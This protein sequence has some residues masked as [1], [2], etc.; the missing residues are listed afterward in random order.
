MNWLRK[1]VLSK[2]VSSMQ[3][4]PNVELAKECRKIEV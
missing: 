3:I 2:Y 4:T 1:E